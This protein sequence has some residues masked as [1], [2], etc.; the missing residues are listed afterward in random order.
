M[1]AGVTIAAY[2]NSFAGIFLFDDGRTIVENLS[3]RHLWPPW[4]FLRGPRPVVD[5]TLAINYAI[6][7]VRPWSYHA[8]NLVVHLLSALTL[9]G[10]VRRTL[11]RLSNPRAASIAFAASLLWAVHPLQTQAVTYI[12]QRSESIMG[13]FYLLTLYLIARSAAAESWRHKNLWYAGAVVACALGMCSKAVM[14][15][16]PLVA[17]L[18]DRAFLASSWRETIQRRWG[19]YL[20]LA[21]TWA[22]LFVTG[23]FGGVIETSA[24]S[25]STVGFG[26]T[27]STPMEYALTQA[28]VILHYLQLA[29]WPHPLC[30]D[31]AW[32]VTRHVADAALPLVVIAV[33][34][35]ATIWACVRRPALGFFGVAFLLILA[36]TSSVVPIQDVAVEH[37]M[38]LPLAVIV[39]LVVLTADRIIRSR[40]LAA[41]LLIIVA[42]VFAVGTYQRN[43]VYA[44]AVTMWQDVVSQRPSNGRAR[45]NL[46]NALVA[47]NR[48]AEAIPHEQALR[49][50]EPN[51]TIHY[52][53]GVALAKLSRTDEAIAHYR[54]AL[55]LFPEH[56][57]VRNNLGM[58]IAEQGRYDEA[59]EHFEAALRIE[60]DYAEARYNLG[61]ALNA[62]GRLVE[63]VEQPTGI[64]TTRQ[65]RLAQQPCRRV[66][67]ATAV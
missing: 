27:R 38:Y 48:T 11:N 46:G 39:V 51:A 15:T 30:L 14:V 53:Y 55:R 2:A 58:L 4:E 63:S 65:C 42:A 7:G 54:E 29:F 67:T 20:A 33:L 41:I 12:I 13:L 64:R 25:H 6:S 45:N 32:P 10:L 44:S 1:I 52:S 24:E 8:V 56:V 61:L 34:L 17:I 16:A 31:Y 28:S 50:V 40:A 66:D 62:M 60:P 49:L 18:Y 36:P 3:I 9:F 26:V 59:I 37:R 5:L 47:A 21:A 22:I 57:K 43:K 23:V 19:L 35:A